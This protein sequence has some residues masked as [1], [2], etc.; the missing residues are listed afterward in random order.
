MA[1]VNVV[2]IAAYRRI[3]AQ[4]DRLGP[5]VGGHLALRATFV[6]CTGWTLTVAV[7]QWRHDKHCR[8]YYCHYYYY[9]S[10]DVCVYWV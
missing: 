4:A 7:P 8:C 1:M 9:S 3:L 2:T 5:K 6:R 10:C